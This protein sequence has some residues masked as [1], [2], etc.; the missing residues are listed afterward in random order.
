MENAWQY[1]KVYQDHVDEN[2]D[3]TAMYWA[4]AKDGW[5]NSWASRYPMGK[6]AVPRYSLWD[7]EKLS[8]IQARNKIYVPLYFK[9]VK[10]TVAY[11]KLKRLYLNEELIYLWDFDGYD[12]ESLDM[13]LK[14]V[15]NHPSKKMGHAFVL[16]SMLRK[17]I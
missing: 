9:A 6:G 2:D 13:T 4:W 11:Q 16:A 12:H 17:G 8:Y 14:D 15:L 1:A 10:N 7:G 5:A 3:P